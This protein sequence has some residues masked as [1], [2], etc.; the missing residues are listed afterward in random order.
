MIAKHRTDR[1]VSIAITHVLTIAITTVLI[2]GLLISAGALLEGERDRSADRSLETI[3]E[4]LAGE[5]SK[6]DSMATDDD[7]TVNMTV[8]HP[9]RAASERYTVTL[10]ETCNEAPLL[11]NGTSC[12]H[13]TTQ[14][15]NVDVY[16]PVTVDVDGDS[17]V[18]GGAIE[19]VHEDGD[20]RL[21]RGS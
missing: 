21:E 4:R 2:S 7:T 19:I 18:H 15:G 3:G 8:N 17:E 14:S 5:L 1:G 9:A 10:R 6:V 20:I 11:E 16:V 12:L 13:L